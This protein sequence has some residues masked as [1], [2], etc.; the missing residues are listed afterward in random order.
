MVG[1]AAGQGISHDRDEKG[2]DV[3]RHVPAVRQ[4]RHGM[5]FGPT[6]DF[7]HHHDEGQQQ[8]PA[9]AFLRSGEFAGSGVDWLAVA[10]VSLVHTL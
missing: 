3:R 6:R 7:H 10:N 4:Q 8:D 1:K 9:R 5:E 2:R